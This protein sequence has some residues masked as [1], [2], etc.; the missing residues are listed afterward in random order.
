MNVYIISYYLKTFYYQSYSVSTLPGRACEDNTHRV[1]VSRLPAVHRLLNKQLFEP[2][3]VSGCWTI[4]VLAAELSSV[5][6]SWS[7]PLKLVY[8]FVLSLCHTFEFQHKM[9]T[10]FREEAP[11]VCV[12]TALSFQ[13]I[14]P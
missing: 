4:S 1:T 11:P 9:R 2:R 14:C 5:R 12:F 3:E 8:V 10:Q 7:F 6:R 13:A